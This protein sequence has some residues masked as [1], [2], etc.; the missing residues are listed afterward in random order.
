M[1]K[2]AALV[3]GLPILGAIAPPRVKLFFGRH[4]TA[5]HIHPFARLHDF[6][7][8]F[9]FN[10]GVADDF[11]QRFVT[12]DVV[13]QGGDIQISDDDRVFILGDRM[14]L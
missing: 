4:M 12:P 9:R 7:E 3:G 13:F 6:C 5:H 11:Q 2:P 8:A 14:I 10:R 1:I